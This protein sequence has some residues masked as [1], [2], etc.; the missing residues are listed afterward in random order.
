MKPFSRYHKDLPDDIQ[1]KIYKDRHSPFVRL[2]SDPSFPRTITAEA[3]H[4][5]FIYGWGD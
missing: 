3:K 2:K 5:L 1:A 4:A